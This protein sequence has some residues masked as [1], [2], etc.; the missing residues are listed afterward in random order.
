MYFESFH[1]IERLFRILKY[2]EMMKKFKKLF[3]FSIAAVSHS[4]VGVIKPL[5]HWLFIYKL[6][7]SD[8]EWLKIK[9][10]LITLAKNRGKIG[11]T[12]ATCKISVAS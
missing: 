1:W 8:A 3:I 10:I 2:A 12:S 6:F 7:T 5:T 11:D 4:L 9:S